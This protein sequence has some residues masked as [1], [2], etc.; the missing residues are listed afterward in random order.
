VLIILAGLFKQIYGTSVAS[1]QGTTQ[2]NL[3]TAFLLEGK[4][5]VTNTAEEMIILIALT[6][7]EPKIR[8][9]APNLAFGQRP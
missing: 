9:T 3:P 7:I 2:T 6:V 5:Q 1:L 4:N 8:I